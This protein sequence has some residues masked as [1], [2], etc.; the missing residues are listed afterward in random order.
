MID[1]FIGICLA[2]GMT[3]CMNGAC[4]I[5]ADKQKEWLKNKEE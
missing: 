1:L 3:I 2:I 5:I 4:L